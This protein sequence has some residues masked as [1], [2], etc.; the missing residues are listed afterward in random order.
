MRWCLAE[1]HRQVQR[2]RAREALCI[3]LAQDQR[4]RRFLVRFRTVSPD[5]EVCEGTLQL[6]K[7]SSSPDNPGAQGIR[8]MTLKAL[9]AGASK[10]PESVSADVPLNNLN[11]WHSGDH[12]QLIQPLLCLSQVTV[13]HSSWS[14]AGVSGVGSRQLLYHSQTMDKWFVLRGICR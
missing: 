3:S 4:G 9:Q 13:F 10:F 14:V 2:Q 11:I 7:V 8:E 6:I 12:I 5:L 1:C